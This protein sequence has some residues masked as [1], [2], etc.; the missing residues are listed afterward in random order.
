MKKKLAWMYALGA[1]VSLSLVS[2][3]SR[4][5]TRD[6]EFGGKKDVAFAE[7]LWNAMEGYQGWKLRSDVIKGSSPHGKWVRMYSTWVMVDTNLYPVIIKDSFGG[8]G[9]TQEKA[10]KD[11]D[12][13]LKDITVMVQRED[14]Y[15]S[16]NQNWF[17]A[18]YLTDGALDKDKK[19]VAVAGRPSKGCISCHSQAAGGDFLFS[20]DEE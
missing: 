8:R 14:R 19:G 16:K 1:L 13:W 9:V 15:D 7:K 18:K 3:S 11:P 20:N 6:D 4:Q 17:Y 10:T 2:Y 12:A 5:S